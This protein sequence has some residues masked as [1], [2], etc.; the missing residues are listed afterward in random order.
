MVFDR[1]QIPHFLSWCIFFFFF[2]KT[3]FGWI[4]TI[5]LFSQ[6]MYNHESSPERKHRIATRV[7]TS[8]EGNLKLSGAIKITGHEIPERKAGTIYQCVR[9]A[10]HKMQKKLDGAPSNVHTSI[11]CNPNAIGTDNL[12]L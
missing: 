11:E 9:C 8:S 5:K 3:Q 6:K 4:R 12:S 10:A 2:H 1:T 7:F